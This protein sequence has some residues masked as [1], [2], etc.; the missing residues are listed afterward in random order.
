MEGKE[1]MKKA[2]IAEAAARSNVRMPPTK[3]Y[4]RMLKE[5]CAS[6]GAYWALRT[7]AH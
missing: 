1:A 5:L 7:G 3:D 2:E 6:R 4:N